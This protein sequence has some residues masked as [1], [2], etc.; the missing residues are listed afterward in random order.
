MEKKIILKNLKRKH[1]QAPEASF[2]A[3][4]ASFFHMV[5]SCPSLHLFWLQVVTDI[6]FVRGLP[7]GLDPRTLLLNIFEDPNMS[8]YVKLF[9]C[10]ISFYARR[11]SSTLKVCSARSCDFLYK[12]TYLNRKF[13]KFDKIWS[14]WTDSWDSGVDPQLQ[15]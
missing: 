14:A 13:P 3:T 4:E 15:P 10:Y 12:L 6:N 11:D 2:W 8:R 7:L 5:W 1:C 9:I